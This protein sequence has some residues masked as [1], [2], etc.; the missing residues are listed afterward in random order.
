MKEIQDAINTRENKA[1]NV[2]QAAV[3]LITI[4]I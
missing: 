3:I 2:W 1:V 4:V